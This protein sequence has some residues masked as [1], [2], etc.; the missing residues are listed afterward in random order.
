MRRC[1]QTFDWYCIVV[2]RINIDP[3]SVP[4]IIFGSARTRDLRIDF[5][6]KKLCVCSIHTLVKCSV[7][8]A[9]GGTE[10]LVGSVAQ[11]SH[12]TVETHQAW[13]RIS[14]DITPVFHWQEWK[15]RLLN[16]RLSPRHLS[17]CLPP[18][19]IR[20]LSLPVPLFA[21]HSP[22]PVPFFAWSSLELF[23][24]FLFR[25]GTFER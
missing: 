8:M 16:N 7:V 4:I 15:R 9:S 12:V 22:D 11:E 20:T 18:H 24:S 21:S 25:C 19:R 2:Q 17:L 1:V 3:W 6:K 10:E 5:W 23:L 14:S 13:P